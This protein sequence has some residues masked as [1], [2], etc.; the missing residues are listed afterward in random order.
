MNSTDAGLRVVYL[1]AGEMH[2][3]DRPSLAITVLGSCLSVTMHN[4]ALGIGGICHCLLPACGEKK[5]CGAGCVEAFR[6]IECS[7][8]QMIG[9]FDRAGAKRSEIEVKCFGGAD[10]FSRTIEK[11]GLASVGRQ[12]IMAAE[13]LIKREGLRITKK[14]LGGLLGRKLYFYTHTGRVLLKRL[15]R[16]DNP[17]IRW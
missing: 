15:S 14:D 5:A 4:P 12:N 10:M 13:A 7:V 16:V 1:R 9:L 17:D 6:Y 11:P 2:F 8:G 3:T